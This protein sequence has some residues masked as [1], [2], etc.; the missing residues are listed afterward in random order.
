MSEF[1]TLFFQ[2]FEE[3]INGQISYSDKF[4]KM[5]GGDERR[6]II[7]IDDV[8]SFDSTLANEI[9][10]NPTSLVDVI[11]SE[12]NRRASSRSTK[13]A[14]NSVESPFHI[15]F[16]GS[17]GSHLVGPR[18]LKTELFTRLICV[19]GI[20]T[21]ASLVR[22][23]IIRSIHYCPEGK[24]K[25][26]YKDYYDMLT[27]SINHA[28]T[29]T[30]IPLANS[31]QEALEFEY[32]YSKY[33]NVQTITIQEMPERAPFGQ[34][35]RS[36]D[37][38][39][40]HDLVDKV[41]PGDRV[42]VFGVYKPIAPSGSLVG[43][44]F[45]S[46]VLADNIQIINT[47]T[48]GLMIS[49]ENIK[50][51]KKLAKRADLFDILSASVAPSIC[52]HDMIKKALVLQMIGGREH[53][54]DNGI[55][56]RGDINILL[57]G[58]PSCGKS[59]LLRFVLNTMPLAVNTTGRGSSG[60]GLTAAVVKDQETGE[61]RLEAGAMVLADRGIVCIDEFDKMSEA[62]RVAIH[63]V[64][65]QQTV[66]I[67]KAGIHCSLNARCSVLAAANPVYG[68]YDISKRPQDNVGLPDS[69]LS[70]FDLLF[71]VRDE[72]DSE[73]D[74]AIAN[75]VLE[76]HR[77]VRP[78]HENI[79]ETVGMEE[80]VEERTDLHQQ[81][82]KGYDGRKKNVTPVLTTHFLQKYIDYAKSKTTELTD[83]AIQYL[84]NEYSELRQK[85]DYKT[86]PVTARLLETLIRLSTA[87]AKMRLS[88][89]VEKKDCEVAMSLVN[90]ALYND[91]EPK[92][93]VKKKQVEEKEVV[94][95][96]EEDGTLKKQKLAED[97]NDKGMDVEEEED[98]EKE[99]EKEPVAEEEKQDTL[100][101]EEYATVLSIISKL[102][103]DNRTDDLAED[104]VIERVQS[105][106]KLT[107]EQ[108]VHC[109]V[110][111]TNENKIFYDQGVL[112]R[113]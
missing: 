69:L 38:M 32:G 15:G 2:F 66:T 4:D 112:Y 10:K 73:Q 53:N 37:I 62:D 65:E 82:V 9:L 51:M 75:H 28:P 101:P 99:V 20:V 45:R 27:A 91:A 11:E 47:N 16:T 106:T 18:E 22:P 13:F 46:I 88:P 56:L 84:V 34:L 54:L 90:F 6:L 52:G 50:A 102:F 29:S 36:V 41:K 100:A 96:D 43:G 3:K 105:A 14:Q 87:H 103:V 8:R 17:F 113:I 49:P 76:M 57:V 55:H 80:D 5:L 107:R 31:N 64:M 92:K 108:I 12:L 44:S 83:D 111:F 77:Y 39:V 30:A 42:R 24:Q 40:S 79:P 93:V 60:V 48:D 81:F 85:A 98:K 95:S 72:M 7:N 97:E 71:I 109:F 86:L 94:F 25:Y 78:G 89:Q 33:M 74:R 23:K 67:A 1:L 26:F 61:R 35:P 70:R 110:T 104:F 19:E 58:D 59:Q 63:E 21:K 68:Q